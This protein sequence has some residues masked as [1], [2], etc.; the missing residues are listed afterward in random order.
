MYGILSSIHRCTTVCTIKSTMMDI[1][2]Y[3]IGVLL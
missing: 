3:T 1:L 2:G